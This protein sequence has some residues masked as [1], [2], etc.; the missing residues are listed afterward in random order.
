MTPPAVHDFDF[1]T[2]LVH[3]YTGEALSE[4]P[5][6]TERKVVTLKRKAVTKPFGA[7]ILEEVNHT[8]TQTEI[9]GELEPVRISRRT[10]S[11]V[12]IV[13]RS[14]S[15]KELC[16]NDIILRVDGRNPPR[17]WIAEQRQKLSL[18]LEVLRSTRITEEGCHYDPCDKKMPLNVKL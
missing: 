13:P 3:G 5:P 1:I 10:Y 9:D 14:S 8:Y 18:H 6:Q 16:L 4:I 17:N 11:V 7:D 12:G 2:K 15:S